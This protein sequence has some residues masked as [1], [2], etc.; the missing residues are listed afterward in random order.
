M[1]DL[2]SLDFIKLLIVAFLVLTIFIY[3]FNLIIN[4]KKKCELIKK[5]KNYCILIAH[6]DDE[7]LFF[8]PTILNLLKLETTKSITILCIT[9]GNYYGQGKLR[10]QEFESCCRQLSKYSGESMHLKCKLLN[11]DAYQDDPKVEWNDLEHLHDIINHYLIQNQINCLITFDS[12]GISSH[13]NHISLNKLLIYFKNTKNSQLD[14]IY[15]LKT[16]FIIRKYMF[17]FD[18]LITYL[19]DLTH[20]SDQYLFYLN[21]PI[22]YFNL[23][24][25]FLE[26]KTQLT[27]FRYLYI[28]NSRY[29]FINYLTL[30]K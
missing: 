7:I 25:C 24:K 6:P 11:L 10:E 29:M 21:T 3:A 17:I 8:G 22:D 4:S 16:C 23:I 26:Y 14:S 13:L 30:Y 12:N 9:N 15:T 5:S 2:L 18:L 27:W 20:N 28:L 1:S 19:C